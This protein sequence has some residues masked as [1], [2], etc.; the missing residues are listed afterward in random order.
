MRYSL[1][2]LILIYFSPLL[3]MD[4]LAIPSD[5]LFSGRI[6]T[7][8]ASAG[9]IKVKVDFS[10]IRYLNKKDQVTFWDQSVELEKCKGLI[11]GKTNEYIL[12]K[13]PNF[14][15][16]EKLAYIKQGAY[17]KFF[18]QDLINNLKMGRELIAILKKKRLALLNKVRKNKKEVDSY[19]E[20]VDA[21]NGR[22]DALSLK[23]RREWKKELSQLEEDRVNALRI[24][25][26]SLSN[27]EDVEFKMERY[28]V[29]DENL[30]VDRW[31]LDTRLFY[32]K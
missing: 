25:K 11:L 24:Y 31:S 8:N 20:K 28:K 15:L 14:Q 7:L 21:L 30:K 6:S 26:S 13:I 16:C 5:G 18:S 2:K 17:L 9:L 3:L 22:Y 10:N 29:E 12:I 1:F 23:L 27:L 32:K 4:T 19:I